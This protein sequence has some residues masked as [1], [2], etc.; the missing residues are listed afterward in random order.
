[1]QDYIN[2]YQKNVNALKIREPTKAGIV[3]KDDVVIYRFSLN[4][5]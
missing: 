1:M 4:F 2:V 5:Q 3:T